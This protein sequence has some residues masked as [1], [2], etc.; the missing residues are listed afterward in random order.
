MSLAYTD[1]V[2]ELGGTPFIRLKG[3][4]CDTTLAE[5]QFALFKSNLSRNALWRV[6]EQ[7]ELVPLEW[8]WWFDNQCL[9]SELDYRTPGEFEAVHYAD[10]DPVLETAMR[11]KP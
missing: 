1:R 4:S 8:G 2:V 3:D 9:H 10:K 5:S 7:V 11:G 6:V